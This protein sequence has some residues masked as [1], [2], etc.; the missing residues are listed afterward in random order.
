LGGQVPGT[1]DTA[2]IDNGGT[3]RVET[4]I[5][6]LNGILDL[7]SVGRQNG[8]NLHVAEGGILQAGGLSMSAGRGGAS[9]LTQTGG[10]IHAMGMYIGGADGAQMRFELSGGSML[11]ESGI[12]VEQPQD[13][14]VRI[15]LSGG[16]LETGR[17]QLLGD[18]GTELLIT[19]GRL[20][21]RLIFGSG[22]HVDRVHVRQTGG[23]VVTSLRLTEDG[24]EDGMYQLEGGTLGASI[25]FAH[26]GYSAGVENTRF[27]MTGGVLWSEEIQLNGAFHQRGGTLRPGETLNVYASYQLAQPATLQA[28]LYRTG[29]DIPTSEHLTAWRM[30]AGDRVELAG[31]LDLLLDTEPRLGE[32][33]VV[34]E[35]NQM[36]IIGTFAG[37]PDGTRFVETF[38]DRAFTF[39]IDYAFAPNAGENGLVTVTV[40]PEPPPLALLSPAAV[41]ALFALGRRL[42]RSMRTR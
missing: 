19:G 23:D 18:S 3:A 11:L 5:A 12:G 13:G 17:I 16:V 28:R 31:S 8:G 10:S 15:E 30:A 34:L 35:T 41:Y 42:A 20:S 24:S 26:D 2:L 1:G 39:E 14:S 7:V 37:L 38:N 9:V 33:F 6:S 32:S 25:N 21:A 4:D 29:F 40:V 36:P 22:N 27:F